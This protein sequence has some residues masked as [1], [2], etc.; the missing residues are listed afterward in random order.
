MVRFSNAVRKPDKLSGFRIVRFS[1][2]FL[3]VGHKIVRFSNAIQ[4]FNIQSKNCG[5]QVMTRKK[6]LV[7]QFAETLF[8]CF[9]TFC[10]SLFFILFKTTIVTCLISAQNIF[11]SL[12]PGLHNRNFNLKNLGTKLN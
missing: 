2:G 4:P 9:L 12:T 7:L 11:R 8:F 10:S 3:L 5:I 6:E 1:N